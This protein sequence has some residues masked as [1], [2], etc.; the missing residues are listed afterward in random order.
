MTNWSNLGN[1]DSTMT[2][3]NI[4]QL[5]QLT[6]YEWQIKTFCDSTNQAEFWMVLLG[7]IHNNCLYHLNLT[8]VYCYYAANTT[9]N[10][11]TGFFNYCSTTTNE[12]DISTSIFFSDKGYFDMN[13]INSGD[14]LG[15]FLL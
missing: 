12:P 15:N 8:Q 14:T 6:T 5:Q 9:C 2:S 3:R 4:P 1:I 10:Q 7:H 11:N 13:N